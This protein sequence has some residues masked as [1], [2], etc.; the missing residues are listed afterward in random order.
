ML[1]GGQVGGW[2]SNSTGLLDNATT[3]EN[4]SIEVVMS[5]WKL[6]P[7]APEAS[8]EEGGPP[9]R[10]EEQT[11]E[12]HKQKQKAADAGLEEAEADANAEDDE[13]DVVDMDEFIEEVERK[14]D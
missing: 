5:K 1:Q 13:E 14:E 12:E 11:D 7:S 10:S 4:G 8:K 9:D 3:A 6:P 2:G